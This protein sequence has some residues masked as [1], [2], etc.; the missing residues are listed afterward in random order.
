MT[1]DIV[2]GFVL[3]PLPVCAGVIGKPLIQIVVASA[4]QLL[5]CD[6][7]LDSLQQ[8]LSSSQ[9][10]LHFVF[11]ELESKIRQKSPD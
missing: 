11:E 10:E 7:L 9:L 5:T 1:P 8:Q 4:P 6:P 3:P 2:Q